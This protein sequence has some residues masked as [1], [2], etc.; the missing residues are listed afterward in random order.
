MPLPV[1]FRYR[2]NDSKPPLALNQAYSSQ[3]HSD[4]AAPLWMPPHAWTK[5]FALLPSQMRPQA[6]VDVIST[7]R[8]S[9]H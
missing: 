4:I 6:R 3:A 5:A 8:T 1:P 9:M 2:H 7:Q